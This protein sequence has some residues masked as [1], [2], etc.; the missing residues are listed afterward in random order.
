MD[1]TISLNENRQFRRV[2]QKGKSFVNSLLVIYF[3][4]NGSNRNRL[5]IAV[6]KKV[7][8]AV[9]RNRV[10][11]LVKESYRLKEKEIKKG[12]DIVFVSRV[13]ARES[14]YDAVNKAMHHLLKRAGLLNSS[15]FGVGSSEKRS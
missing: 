10:R 14:S 15:A 1:N 6:N 9:V 13:R 12:Y 8:K 2:Y 3:L 7:G 4:K 11:R 5:G